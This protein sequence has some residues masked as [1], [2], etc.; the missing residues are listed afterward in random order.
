MMLLTDFKEVKKKEDETIMEFN[1]RFQKLIDKIHKD[2]RPQE[3]VALLY[4]VNAFEGNFGL[5][6]RDKVPKDL[7]E[8]QE[9][10]EKIKGN[11]PLRER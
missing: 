3:N 11:L 2:I 5:L 7:K 1:T 8:A 10:E 6:L 4:Y 9:M